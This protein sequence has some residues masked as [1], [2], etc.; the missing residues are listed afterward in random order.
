MARHRVSHIILT[1]LTGKHASIELKR[2][3]IVDKGKG[4]GSNAL[5]LLK[6]LAR[7]E[8][9][10]HRLWLDEK[11]LNARAV[12][13]RSRWIVEEGILRECLKSDEGFESLT[14]MAMLRRK[15]VRR[16]SADP[17]SK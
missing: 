17:V 16:P 14:D 8:W 7:E 12:S 1:G 5:E 9:N 6:G 10:T 15:C 13:V 11:V 2:I 3:V 4:Y